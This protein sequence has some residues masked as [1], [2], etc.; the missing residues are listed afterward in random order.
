MTVT[1]GDVVLT[2]FVNS[3]ETEDRIVAKI[4][5]IRG[6]KIREESLEDGREKV[7]RLR[8]HFNYGVNCG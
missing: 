1:Q 6:C 5:E 2:G 3:R 8:Q 7:S 4:R